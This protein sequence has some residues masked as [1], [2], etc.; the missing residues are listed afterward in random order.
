MSKT[1]ISYSELNV[2]DVFFER[3]ADFI[4]SC[5]VCV[6]WEGASQAPLILLEPMNHH[7]TLSYMI[8][9]LLRDMVLTFRSS[10]EEG[11]RGCWE[12]LLRKQWWHFQEACS[13]PH[14]SL[15]KK[16]KMPGNDTTLLLSRSAF[17]T[18][19]RISAQREVLDKTL[20]CKNS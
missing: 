11:Q 20:A 15:D 8:A 7:Y 2:A 18:S 10:W 14:H 12:E 6:C 17:Q 4:K 16:R 3:W 13:T 19:S 1:N 9:L 5:C